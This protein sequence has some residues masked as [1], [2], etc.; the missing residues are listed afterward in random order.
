MYLSNACINIYSHLKLTPL[1]RLLLNQKDKKI[2]HLY[3]S[4]D[5]T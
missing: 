4:N 2:D 5:D 3:A 1:V